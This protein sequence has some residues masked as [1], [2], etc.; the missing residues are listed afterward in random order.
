MLETNGTHVNGQADSENA[1]LLQRTDHIQTTPTTRERTGLR[2]YTTIFRHR[3]FVCGAVS[4]LVFALLVSS[5]DTTLPLHVRAVFGWGS[6]PTG[7]LFMALQSPGI[8]LSPLVGWLKDRVGT[9]DPIMIGFLLLAP[10]LWLLGVPGDERFPWASQ[11]DRGPVLYSISVTLI[12]ITM[13]LL[14][15]AG[16]MEATSMYLPVCSLPTI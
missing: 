1:P 3:R 6:L 2:F 15:G 11:G 13:C 14:N 16:T 5:F 7:L 9:R 10:Q 4:Y 8:P 12:G